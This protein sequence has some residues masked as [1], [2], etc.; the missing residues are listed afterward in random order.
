MVLPFPPIHRADDGN[1]LEGMAKVLSASGQYRVLRAFQ[2]RRHYA[3]PGPEAELR[4]GVVVDVETTGTVAGTD[5]IIELAM[6]PFTFDRALGV[7][8][9]ADEPVSWLEDPGMPI[10]E[11]VVELTGITDA[12]VAGTRIDDEAATAVLARADLV[13]AHNARFDRPFVE[14]RLPVAAERYWAC[15]LGEIAWK[16]RGNPSPA[17]GALLITHAGEFPPE[18]DD[19]RAHRAAT[20]CAMT[21]HLLATPHAD[22]TLPFA[23]LLASARRKTTRVSAIGAPFD[24]KDLLKARGYAWNGTAWSIERAPEQVGDETAW[25]EAHVYDGGARPGYV[26]EPVSGRR[27]YSARGS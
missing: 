9:T 19:A 5:R 4:T 26:V 7:V 22:G 8:L 23:T 3:S 2:P 6:L 13:I 25:L 24:R 18:G 21:L 14:A 20:D 16:E 10:P 17:L 12:M 1:P 11:R 15:S 27:R